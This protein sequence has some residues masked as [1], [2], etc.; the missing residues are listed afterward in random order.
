MPPVIKAMDE[1]TDLIM[2]YLTRKDR[3]AREMDTI[4]INNND[5]V[6]ISYLHHN[7]GIYHIHNADERKAVLHYNTEI[8]TKH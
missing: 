3:I 4:D 5:C 1:G 7:V 2:T 6:G 8:S